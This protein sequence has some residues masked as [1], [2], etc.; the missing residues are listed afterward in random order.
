[1]S[2]SLLVAIGA[3]ASASTAQTAYEYQYDALGRL[4]RAE[5][6][7]TPS[8]RTRYT[9]D[10]A[11][12]RA[13]VKHGISSPVA[14]YDY[15]LMETTFGPWSLDVLY[16]DTDADLPYDTL[17]ITNVSGTGSGYATI[18]GGGTYIDFSPPD[19]S[20]SLTYTIQDA[21][22]NTSNGTVDVDVFHIT[23]GEYECS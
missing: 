16:N 12:N 10:S 15:V 1:M 20:Y 5:R 6:P 9:Y 2:F 17:T 14:N 4:V 7:A 19:G 23:C 22:G 3:L 18:A 8:T 11:D 13:R 21:D